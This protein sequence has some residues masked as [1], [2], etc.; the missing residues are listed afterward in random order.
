M[1]D[2]IMEIDMNNIEDECPRCGSTQPHL[3]PAVQ[4]EGEVELCTH[5]FHLIP[6]PQNTQA[7]IANVLKKRG[8][9]DQA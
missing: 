8:R 3:H 7:H 1:T 5:D 2:R 9:H 6:T 4:S